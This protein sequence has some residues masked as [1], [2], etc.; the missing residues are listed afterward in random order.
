ME[1]SRAVGVGRMGAQGRAYW[2]G[3]R[4]QHVVGTCRRRAAENAH[5]GSREMWE[6]PQGGRRQ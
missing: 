3:G 2:G 6:S 4:G 1:A 5:G